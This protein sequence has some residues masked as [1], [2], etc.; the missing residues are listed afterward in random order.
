M[1]LLARVRPDLSSFRAYASARRSGFEARI[2]LDANECP[3]H[4]SGDDIALNRYPAPQRS[5]GLARR[6]TVAP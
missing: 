4:A 5:Q 6:R 3:W 1:S 2:R